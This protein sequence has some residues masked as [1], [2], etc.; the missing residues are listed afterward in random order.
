VKLDRDKLIRA[1]EMLGYGIE[2]VA[3][4]AGVSKNSV[5]RAEHEEDIRPLTARK[6]AVALGVRVADLI[7]ESETLKAE[8]SPSP[9]QPPLNGFDE[10]RRSDWEARVNEARR[11]RESGW[12]Q[13]WRLLSDW[14]ASKKRGEARAARRKYLDEMGSLLQ[15]AYDAD[16]ALGRAY[17]DAAF[18][19][20]GGSDAD[21]AR[22][23]QEESRAAGHFYGELFG[24]VKSAGLSIDTGAGAGNAK[25]AHAEKGPHRIEESPAA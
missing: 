1:R 21:V 11:L 25:E 8:A 13:M 3:E 4:E 2:T 18:T 10:E 12:A 19:L 17:L 5:L 20:V 16:F 15:E 14:R 6:I 24:L 22:Y 7:G 23:L 9:E